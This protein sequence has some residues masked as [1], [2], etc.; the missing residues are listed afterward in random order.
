MRHISLN[1]AHRTEWSAERGQ[2]ERSAKVKER[3]NKP[4][5]LELLTLHILLFI[6]RLQTGAFSQQ[7]L[8]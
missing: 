4:K 3:Q 6:T 5:S 7:N 1:G 8:C 2:L